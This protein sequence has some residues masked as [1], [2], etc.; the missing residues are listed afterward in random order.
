MGNESKALVLPQLLLDIFLERHHE[1]EFCAFLHKPTTTMAGLHKK[2]PVLATAIASLAALY[3][4][5][6]DVGRLTKALGLPTCTLGLSNFYAQQATTLGR[7][8]TD[9]PSSTAPSFS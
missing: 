8:L 2:A 1:V 5:A 9:Q 7:H 4:T 6:G 3:L